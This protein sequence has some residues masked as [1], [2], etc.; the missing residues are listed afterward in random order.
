MGAGTLSPLSLQILLSVA[1]RPRYGY[2]MIREIEWQTEGAIVPKSG[3]LYTALQ[4][5]EEEGLIAPVESAD[6]PA[7]SE[8]RSYYR[9]S[10]R[11]REALMAEISRLERFVRIAGTRHVGAGPETEGA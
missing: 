1:D 3:S 6:A 4:R 7:E 8:R 5:L 10:D 9:L 2:E 11:G